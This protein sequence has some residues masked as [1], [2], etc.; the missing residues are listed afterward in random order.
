MS[1]FF[2]KD[3]SQSFESEEIVRAVSLRLHEELEIWSQIAPPVNEIVFCN[4]KAYQVQSVV[5]KQMQIN[6]KMVDGFSSKVI[7]YL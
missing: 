2:C 5:P 3:K 7:R 6:D 4:E 1:M